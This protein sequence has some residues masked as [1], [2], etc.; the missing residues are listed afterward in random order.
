MREPVLYWGFNMGSAAAQA[1]AACAGLPLT[2]QQV[3][4]GHGEHRNPDYLAIN[5]AGKVPV[6]GLPDSSILTERAAIL[7]YLCELA[8]DRRLFPAAGDPARLEALRWLFFMA[9]DRYATMVINYHYDDF[10][11]D[12]VSVPAPIRAKARDDLA[13]QFAVLEKHA[14]ADKTWIDGA[15]MGTLDIYAAMILSWRHWTID[16]G[17]HYP[18]LARLEAAVWEEPLV[19]AS[20]RQHELAAPA[21]DAA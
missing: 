7:L 13:D 4:F 18:P 16:L 17:S 1:I 12:G 6:L 21:S 15:R 20:L 2:L 8:P 14:L 19:G 3:N 5:P 11:A 10:E 9:S